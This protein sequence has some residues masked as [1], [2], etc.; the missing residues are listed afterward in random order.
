MQQVCKFGEEQMF[1]LEGAKK[2][3]ESKSATFCLYIFIPSG[4]K[5]SEASDV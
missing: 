4:A 1:P 3:K 2:K 5:W